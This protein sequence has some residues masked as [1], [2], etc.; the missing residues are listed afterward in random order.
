MLAEL[1]NSGEDWRRTAADSLENV[2]T[3]LRRGYDKDAC[4]TLERCLRQIRGYQTA[5][6]LR[7][8]LGAIAEGGSK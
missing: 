2:A 1:D 6:T 4:E 3:T 8:R 7:E 5:K